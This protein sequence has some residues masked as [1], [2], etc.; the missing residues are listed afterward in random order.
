M[1]RLFQLLMCGTLFLGISAPTWGQA[2]TQGK[3][4][5]VSSSIVCSPSN[6]QGIAP[7]IAISAEKACEVTIVGGLLDAQGNPSINIQKQT[8]AA[9]SWN[10]FGNVNKTYNNTT[11]YYNNDPRIG[12]IN[13]QMDASKWYPID[14]K[15][16]ATVCNLAGQQPMYGL[17]IT[18]TENI[19]VYVVLGGNHAMDASNI[20]PMTA[21]GDE[22]YVQDYPAEAHNKDS[23]S[24]N[25]G[26]M[27]TVTTILGTENSTIV[28]ITP[29][30]NTY[31]GHASGTTYQITLNQGQVYYLISQKESQLA[32]THIFARD[33]KKIAI[34]TGSPLTRLPNEVSARDALFEQPLPIEYWGTK[35]IVTRSLEKNGNLIGI[36]ASQ[37]KT[38]IV[39]DGEEITQ[40]KEAGDTYY[41]MLQSASDPNTKT[42]GSGPKDT[43][44]TKDAI[45]IE[46]SCPCAIYNYDTGNGYKG[47][48][49]SEI[50]NGHGDPS[51]VWVSPLQQK[52]GR[53]TFG[54]CYTSKTQN[55]F[56]NVVTETAKCKETKLTALYGVN[57]ID[58][59]EVLVWQTVPGN[60]KYSY[61]RAEIGTP[62]TSQYSVFRLE[63]PRGFIATIYGNGEDESYAYSAGSAAVEHGI[64]VN[65]VSFSDGYRS[66]EK[67][68]MD[69]PIEFDASIGADE[70]K[71]V[72]WDF[73]DGTTEPNGEPQTTHQYSNPGWYD[74]TATLYGHQVCTNNPDVELGTVSFTFRT[75]RQDTIVGD[76]IHKCLTLKEQKDDP[77]GCADKLANG[78]N[79][80]S[81]VDCPETVTINIVE[82]G[83]E[84]ES[85]EELTGQNEYTFRG[86]TYYDDVVIEDTTFND[87]GCWHFTHYKIHVL[88][89]NNFKVENN[90]QA[91]CLDKNGRGDDIQ[92]EYTNTKGDFKPTAKFVALRYPALKDTAINTTVNI[93]TSGKITLP[94]NKIGQPSNYKGILTVEDAME[95][96]DPKEFSI[97]FTIQYPSEIFKYKFNNVL[98]VY[99]PGYGGNKGWEFTHY[100][101]H[102]VKNSDGKNYIVG[103]DTPVLYLGDG[104]TFEVGDEVYVVLTESGSEPIPSC[105]QTIET[106]PIYTDQPSSAPAQKVIRN[107]RIVVLKDGKLYDMYGQRIE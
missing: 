27:V 100:E 34:Y 37:P 26:N 59:T 55:H 68:C 1:K 12:P 106:V 40:L 74:V 47:K 82:Y 56:L 23:W 17:H 8:V 73:G 89:C 25:A 5:W 104:I 61:A 45:Y 92:V 13:V 44:L 97:D 66:D 36:T 22:Y 9:G 29:R 33:K 65:G 15:E 76:V 46:T 79:D 52:I 51:S 58:K 38:S 70:I 50:V 86:V 85:T 94:T 69:G 14:T 83:I 67:F 16:P 105:S 10:E 21:L 7:Y 20:L 11:P 60:K 57:Q 99:N 80:T 64:N 30:G 71:R 6:G 95:G 49:Y 62:N 103:T 81:K 31:D 107:Q 43:V 96:C 41:M 88:Q 4:F 84:T 78:G 91:V 28:D 42:P 3:D 48:S 53:I 18:A 35:F 54:T 2:S 102:R 63:N 98:A 39:V 72:D 101:W 32:G 93:G 75:W 90:P 87:Y 77:A 24:T 19:S